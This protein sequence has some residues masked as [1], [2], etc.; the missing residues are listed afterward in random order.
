M[1]LEHNMENGKQEEVWRLHKAEKAEISA[2]AVR[3]AKRQDKTTVTLKAP[4]TLR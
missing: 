4:V 2:L 1:L 3:K